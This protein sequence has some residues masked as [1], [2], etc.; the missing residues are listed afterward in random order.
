MFAG[1]D[2]LQICCFAYTSSDLLDLHFLN[3][4]YASSTE[5]SLEH[6]IVHTIKPSRYSTSTHPSPCRNARTKVLIVARIINLSEH[7]STVLIDLRA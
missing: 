1:L 3:A 4:W 7:H 6:V 5:S 2:L